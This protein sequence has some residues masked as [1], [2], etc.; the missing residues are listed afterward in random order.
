ELKKYF[1]ARSAKQVV[2]LWCQ[3]FFLLPAQGPED[4]QI[5]MVQLR[6]PREDTI[7]YLARDLYVWHGIVG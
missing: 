6:H 3:E 4:P 5:L 2:S 7:K 1:K